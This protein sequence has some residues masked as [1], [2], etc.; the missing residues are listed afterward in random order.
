MT[1]KFIGTLAREFRVSSRTLRF[2]EAMRLLPRPARTEGGYR[3]YGD[4]TAQEADL[5]RHFSC[6]RCM[7]V[8]TS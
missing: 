3:V 7:I 5:A 4:E 2:Y 6:R 1:G 8:T